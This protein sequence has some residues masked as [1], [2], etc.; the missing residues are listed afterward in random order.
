M[1]SIKSKKAEISW[2]YIV[3]MVVGIIGLIVVL[4]ILFQSKSKMGETVSFFQSLFS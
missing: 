3:M 2:F 1:R 4:S